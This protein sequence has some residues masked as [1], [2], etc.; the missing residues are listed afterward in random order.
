MKIKMIATLT[1]LAFFLSSFV[2]AESLGTI[3]E[4]KSKLLKSIQ[5]S[6]E[7]NT[8]PSDGLGSLWGCYN[9]N[10]QVKLWINGQAQST[11]AIRNIK[12]AVVNF[13]GSKMDITGKIWA[14]IVAE[15][16][17][18]SKAE[19]VKELFQQCPVKKTVEV[20]GL[21]LFIKCSK[22]KKADEHILIVYP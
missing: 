14:G 19:Y 15:E 9:I 16:Y 12:L 11:S 22:G 6:R 20:N 8:L 7:S 18:G 13:H 17:G 10:E 5:C 21:E 4:E 3:G 2:Y 1:L